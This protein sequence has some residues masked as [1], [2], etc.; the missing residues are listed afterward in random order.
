L[1]E[2]ADATLDATP[3]GTEGA[4]LESPPNSICIALGLEIRSGTLRVFL[5]PLASARSFIDLI[6]ALEATAGATDIPVLVEGYPPPANVGISGFQI[7]PDPGVIEVNIHP[8][9]TWSALV[10]QTTLLYEEA[11]QSRLGTEKY[12]LEG[13]RISTGG[14]AHITIGGK[15]RQESP[16]LQPGQEIAPEVLDCLLGNLLVDV[17][18]NS[19]RTALCID[20]LYP[21]HNP[22]LQLG[23][24]EFRGFAMPP[25][26]H[27]RL[28]QLLLIRALVAKFWHHPYTEPLTRWG[29]ALHDRF[30]LPYYLRQ[31]LQTAIAELHQAGYRFEIDWFEPFLEFRFPTY[32]I[33]ALEDREG[34]PM[35]LELRQAIEPWHVIGDDANSG[36][37]SRTVDASMERMQVTLRGADQ[38]NASPYDVICHHYRIPLVKTAMPGEWVG[39]V[40]FRARQKAFVSHPA[41]S[42]I[43]LWCLRWWIGKRGDRGED[44]LIT[45]VFLTR[46]TI[47][48]FPPTRL[49]PTLA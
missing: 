31:D 25:H 42:P 19:H 37:S 43:C 47:G 10:E 4:P 40:R 49:K 34:R 24:L 46:R 14:G 27:M 6:T 30:L 28:L 45:L 12:T 15:T 9:A 17:T 1:A 5:P 23:L 33:V 36:S 16:S 22:R 8:A 18:G 48:A 35:Q 41:V 3:I 44:V 20:K 2:E 13:H 26:A 38:A 39:G 11:R 7:A 32:G 21:S 29:T